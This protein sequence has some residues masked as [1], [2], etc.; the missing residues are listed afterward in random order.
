MYRRAC[1]VRQCP[2]LNG[3]YK[4]LRERIS[5][6]VTNHQLALMIGLPILSNAL[7]YGLLFLTLRKRFN[8]LEKAMAASFD[9]GDSK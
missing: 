6:T 7:L 3:G 8:E 1:G 4:Q 9:R 2:E 5:R